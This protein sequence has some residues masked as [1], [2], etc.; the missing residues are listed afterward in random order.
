MSTGDGR[1]G[2]IRSGMSRGR[3]SGKLAG[4]SLPRQILTIAFWP[5]LEQ[6]MSF[7]GSSVS[8]L[9]ATHMDTPPEVTTQIA[10]GM[11]AI[12]SVFFLGFVMQGAVSMGATA[13]VS[14]MTGARNFEEAQHAANQSAVLGLFV[15]ILSALIMYF[16]ADVLLD[17]VFKLTPEAQD[18]A[19]RF[20]RTGACV[21]IFSG[22]VFAVNSALRGAGDTRLPFAM[23]LVA[24]GLNIVVSLILVY[25]FGLSIEGMALGMVVG[26]AAAALLLVGILE[27]RRR[28]LHRLANGLSLDAYAQT[29]GASYAPPLGLSMA[30]F[31]PDFPMIRRIIN[32]GLP[33]SVEVFGMWAIQLYCLSVISRLGDS[34]LGAHTIAIRIESLSFLPGFAI[35]TASASLVGLYLG[36]GSA[37]MALRTIYKCTLYSVCFMGTMGLLFFLFPAFFVQIFAGNSAS[38]LA[39]GIP[40]V[41]VFLLCEPFFASAIVM[42]MSLRGAGDTR[43]VMW[44]TYGS[45]GFFRLF[46]LWSWNHF[47]PETLNLTWIWVIFSIDMMM[48]TAILYRFV[49]DKKW[50]RRKV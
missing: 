32:I 48:Q 42:K 38:L 7:I 6:V 46:I 12:G 20:V 27:H 47:F 43:R 44:V 40:V 16:S 23:M 8:M 36:A 34:V 19:R 9:I 1:Y 33:Q 13:I 10:A 14:R 21:A 45:M 15:G 39:A 31:S 50:V 41:K 3:L 4:L 29:Q 37:R 30:D 28:K 5:L 2:A 24:D 35:G 22:L 17:D 25:C 11:G 26:F 49:I 18:Y